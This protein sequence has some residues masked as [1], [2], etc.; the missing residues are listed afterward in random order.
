MQMHKI[1]KTN[2]LGLTA[3]LGKGEVKRNQIKLLLASTE[4]KDYANRDSLSGSRSLL[5][6]CIIK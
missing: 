3:H 5:M 1:A 2:I 4:N 6:L